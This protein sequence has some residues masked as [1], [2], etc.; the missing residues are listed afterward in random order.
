MRDAETRAEG[1]KRHPPGSVPGR[2][3]QR[4]PRD[5]CWEYDGATPA[6]TETRLESSSQMIKE[7]GGG[8]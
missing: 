5:G 1:P 8:G 4:L 7:G 6:P 2:K 3:G